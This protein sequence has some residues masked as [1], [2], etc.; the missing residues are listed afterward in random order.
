MPDLPPCYPR[1]PGRPRGPSWE[2]DTEPRGGGGQSGG[3][4]TAGEEKHCPSEPPRRSSAHLQS[5]TSGCQRAVRDAWERAARSPRGDLSCL[6]F[7]VMGL[8]ERGSRFGF[9][10]FFLLLLIAVLF[11]GR[12]R[13]H[14]AG[15]GP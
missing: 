10:I 8:T 3:G 15:A 11:F 1:S 14:G 5:R 12:C 9:V 6:S 2:R 13:W 7:L 4:G